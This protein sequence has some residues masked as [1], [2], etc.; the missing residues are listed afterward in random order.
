MIRLKVLRND[1]VVEVTIKL[2]DQ[3]LTDEKKFAAAD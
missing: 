1:N 2:A 3:S